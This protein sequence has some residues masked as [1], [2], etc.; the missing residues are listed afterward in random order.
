MGVRK[1]NQ[2]KH[3]KNDHEILEK[4][5]SCS[6]QFSPPSALA[7]LEI[8]SHIFDIS[9]RSGFEETVTKCKLAKEGKNGF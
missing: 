2:K 9:V 1:R 8:L 5:I 6:C 4:I 3:L 7:L